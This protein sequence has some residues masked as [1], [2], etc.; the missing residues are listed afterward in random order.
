MSP[1]D[2]CAM[3]CM[4]KMGICLAGLAAA[5]LLG[6][7]VGR[8]EALGGCVMP[9]DGMWS[10][11]DGV[12]ADAIPASF[13]HVVAVPGL[14]DQAKPHFADVD[15]Y[16]TYEYVQN[17]KEYGTFPPNEECPKSGRT[18]QTRKYFW[19]ER[20]FNVPAKRDSA[21]LVVARRSLARPFGST[22]K[23]SASIWGAYGGPVRRCRS[24]QLGWREPAR[25]PHRGPPRRP[26]RLG[27]SRH[28][29]RKG[30][31]DAGHLR[32]RFARAGRL[33]GD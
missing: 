21:V 4:P 3:R 30:T 22:E 5:L 32:S 7:A 33:A 26:A 16:E 2:E 24:D 11:A 6:P 31:V 17:R 14:T 9:L 19:Y 15:Q 29:H 20:T 12:G 1:H 27:D 13:D 25:D 8:S 23:R 18:R 10:V 28:G